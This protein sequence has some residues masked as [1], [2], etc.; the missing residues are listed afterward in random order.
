M[1]SVMKAT[2]P[3]RTQ[4]KQIKQ[5]FTDF[6]KISG[7]NPFHPSHPSSN[8]PVSGCGFLPGCSRDEFTALLAQ[9]RQVVDARKS[10]DYTQQIAAASRKVV[11]FNIKQDI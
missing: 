7:E 9:E 8:I 10:S 4:I 11:T 1:D 5:I 6:Y 3:I 2:V